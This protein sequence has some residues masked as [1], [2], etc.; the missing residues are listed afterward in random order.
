ML[1]FGDGGDEESAEICC[2]AVFGGDASYALGGYRGSALEKMLPVTMDV[3]NRMDLPNTA[4]VLVIDKSSS[5]MEGQ[6]GMTRMALAREAAC[7]AL[8]VLNERDQAGVIAFDDAGKWV[9]PLT[10]VTDVEAM[11]AQIATIRAEGGTAFYTPLVMAAEAL[12]NAPA[13]YRHVI[14]LTDGEA[15]DTGYMN[16]VRQMAE[17]GITVTTV[18]VGD[19]ADWAGL[20]AMAEAGKGRM[21]AAGPFDSLP[22]IFT[23]ETMMISG[24]YVQN[25]IFTPAVT[26]E[27]MT[28]FPGFP[29]LTGYLATTEKA[30][31]TVSLV[32]DRNDP[33]LAWWQYGAG[34]VACWM[35]DIRGGWTESFLNWDR[36]TAFFAGILSFVLPDRG[37]EGEM[38]LAD[39]K[40]IWEAE[41]PEETVGASAVVMMP[42]G[43]RETVALERVSQTRFEGPAATG[44]RGVYAI[45]VTAADGEGR[46]TMTAES[47]AVIGWTAEYDLRREDTGELERLAEESGGKA[48]ESA[49]GLLSFPD[50]AARK[51][52]DLTP[53]LSGLALA[54]FLLDVAQRR[55]DLFREPAAQEKMEKKEEHAPEGPKAEKKK[56]K[57]ED[58][59]ENTGNAADLLWENM[60][61]KKRM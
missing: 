30:L 25:R 5:M 15:G 39:G 41:V 54:L 6:Y 12:R 50:T 34:R 23:K 2:I 45:R 58:Q 8:E 52:W 51:R 40:L 35:S 3:R 7:S 16:V 26:D 28:D 47:G 9:I 44:Q 27:S 31:A 22:R 11:K 33:I 53:L 18:A 13:R 19:G 38:T 55:L 14:F 1:G 32:S 61:N 37:G 20:A 21:Y 49:A 57:A 10:Y 36:G 48:L 29:S 60:K 46:E 42:D 17:E 24:A 43:G 56:R 59:K 4:L